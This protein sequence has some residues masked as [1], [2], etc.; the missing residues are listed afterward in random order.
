MIENIVAQN[1]ESVLPIQDTF[2]LSVKTSFSVYKETN[3]KDC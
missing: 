2:G 1:P 3:S